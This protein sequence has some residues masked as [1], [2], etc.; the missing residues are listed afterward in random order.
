[1]RKIALPLFFFAA[2]PTLAQ[3]NDA[4]IK[5]ESPFQSCSDDVIAKAETVPY[6]RRPDGRPIIPRGF[7]ELMEIETVTPEVYAQILDRMTELAD[8]DNLSTMA[9]Y[10]IQAWK[11]M[12]PGSVYAETLMA[13]FKTA[14]IT[15]EPHIGAFETA[16]I[17]HRAVSVMPGK[18][19]LDLENM[20]QRTLY[21]S[22]ATDF[23][24]TARMR[25]HLSIKPF[26]DNPNLKN[27]LWTTAA[28]ALPDPKIS[29]ADADVIKEQLRFAIETQ[30][31]ES[32]RN[33]MRNML[34][35][36]ARERELNRERGLLPPKETP[37]PP[38]P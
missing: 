12:P 5:K 23:E 30:C 29:D 4:P 15:A 11:K 31:N 20:L 28:T 22:E 9:L 18:I 2:S 26:T 34:D 1:M 14:L 33:T 27:S 8:N 10:A 25:A 3:D 36:L 13:R 21:A 24:D 6:N 38:P 7:L 35:N 16:Q 37:A 17:V 19:P 32:T